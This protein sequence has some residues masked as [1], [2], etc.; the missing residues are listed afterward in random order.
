VPK[1]SDLGLRKV[2]NLPLQ[3]GSTYFERIPECQPEGDNPRPR[4]KTRNEFDHSFS[5]KGKETHF[6]SRTISVR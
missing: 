2:Q 6:S 5:F 4:L 1:A 3:H